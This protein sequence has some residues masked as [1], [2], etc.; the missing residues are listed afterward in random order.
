VCPIPNTLAD[1]VAM[2]FHDEGSKEGYSF[3]EDG[4]DVLRSQNIT[5]NYFRVELPDGRVLVHILSA[6]KPFN[7][8][9]G[10]SVESLSSPAELNFFIEQLL[11]P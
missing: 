10:R 5:D 9:F 2:T 8:Q 11:L 4:D 1:K 3:E 7:L 6:G